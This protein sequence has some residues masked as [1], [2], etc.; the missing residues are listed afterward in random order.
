MKAAIHTRYG[1]PEVVRISEVEKPTPKDNEVLVRVHATTV[2]QT[3]CGIR[4]AKP[5]LLR[6]F[7]GLRRPWATIIGTEFAGMVEAVG[8]DVTSFKAGDSPKCQNPILVLITPLLGG[9]KVKVSI[10]ALRPE[11]GPGA[12][13]TDRVR[14][15]QAAVDRVY[16]L[17]QIV[18]A[19]EYVEAGRKIGNVVV[20]VGPSN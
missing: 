20:T 1:P 11:D 18:E 13:G 3:D 19:Y 14:R 8:S 9:K 15:I 17:D 4:A 5:S 2:N 6:L 10:P 16:P 7:L 12:Q